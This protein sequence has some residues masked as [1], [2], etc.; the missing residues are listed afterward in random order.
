MGGDYDWVRR[1][2]R[3]RGRGFR[4]DDLVDGLTPTVFRTQAFR[5][6]GSGF[7]SVLTPQAPDTSP[8]KSIET[9]Q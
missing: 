3:I 7:S 6:M 1:R 5:F 9:K 8:F 2:T 4:R